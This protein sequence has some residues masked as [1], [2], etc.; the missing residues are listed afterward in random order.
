MVGAAS[1]TSVGR[2]GDGR[3]D[4]SPLM[5]FAGV[6]ATTVLARTAVGG[7][8]TR[9]I[10]FTELAAMTREVAPPSTRGG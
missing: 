9:L 7:G 8:M 10:P 4:T 3:P 1:F 6:A 2:H 5:P